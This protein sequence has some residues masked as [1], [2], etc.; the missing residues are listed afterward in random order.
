MTIKAL[1]ISGLT[2]ALVFACT[3]KNGYSA[4]ASPARF[5]ER[6]AQ[7]LRRLEMRIAQMQEQ[8]TCIAAATSEDAIKACR[9]R[10]KPAK[11]ARQR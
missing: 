1:T 5:E 9:E 10:F 3:V 7:Q 11:G 4:A 8:R 2:A 6:K